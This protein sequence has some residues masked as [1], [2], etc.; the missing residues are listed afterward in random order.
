MFRPG[1]LVLA[2]TL[3]VAGC[4]GPSSA[5]SPSVSSVA[6]QSDDLP[7]GMVRCDLTGDIA[8][9]IKAEASPDPTTSKTMSTEWEN[10]KSKGA[11][12]GYAAVYSDSSDH[13]AG[14][15]TSGS[16]IGSATYKLVV[17]F[18]IQYKD[19]KSA[20]DG[21]TSESI[22]GFSPA[23][24]KSGGAPVVEG[25][26]TGLTANSITLTQPFD[27]QFFYIAVWQ[28]KSFVVILAVLNLDAAAA[29]K[30]ATS[31]NGRIK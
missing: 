29:K 12:D 22:L 28:N 2:A 16:D 17:N 6:V 23:S 4:S 5:Q 8:S 13:C 20:S 26:S 30:V 1:V 31:E 27:K 25:S 10:A 3:L 21:Y 11:K 7:S 24:L 14:I 15:K 18:V 19:E 9:F